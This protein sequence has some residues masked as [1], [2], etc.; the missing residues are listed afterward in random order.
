MGAR[1]ARLLA[2]LALPPCV[3]LAPRADAASPRPAALAL[4]PASPPLACPPPLPCPAVELHD[5]GA[6]PGGD[7]CRARVLGLRPGYLDVE[8]QNGAFLR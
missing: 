3:G 7:Y 4:I 5:A 6:A 2:L 1:A 8:V